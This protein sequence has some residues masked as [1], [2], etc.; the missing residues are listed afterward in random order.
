MSEEQV[1]M[2]IDPFDEV[3]EYE[4][5]EEVKEEDVEPSEEAQDSEDEGESAESEDKGDEDG[6]EDSSEEDSEKEANSESE[7]DEEGASETEPVEFAKA[8]EDG[9]LEIEVNGETVTL[10][11]MK[12]DYIGQKEISR[13][14]S[15]IDVK[16]KQMEADTKEI[17]EYINT[18]AGHLKNGD[19]IGAMQYFGEFAGTPPYMVKEQL[20]AAL[21]PEIL[22]RESMSPMEIQNE[23]LNDQNEYLTQQR[24]SEDE[25]RQ[26]E[27]ANQELNNSINEIREANE[28]SEKEWQ[29][30]KDYLEKN[31]AEGKDVTPELVKDTVIYSRMYE[32]AEVI[33]KASGEN[34][35]QEQKWIEELVNVKEQYPDFTDDDLKEVLANALESSK[36]TNTEQKMAK[37]LETKKAPSKQ[38]TKQEPIQEDEIDP[39]L[40]DWL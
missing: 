15:E 6:S 25:R 21:R 17:N 34:L 22:R 40:D 36:K 31:L 3:V 14:F 32:Q 30:T 19:A 26:V 35:E 12:N 10:K 16:S 1:D 7:P 20:I 18:F 27:Q 24:K 37:K 28:I 11:D 23:T 38:K 5:V 29:S 9:S 4:P 33:V 8:I 39:E 13:R 2:S